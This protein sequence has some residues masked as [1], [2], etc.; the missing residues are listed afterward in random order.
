MLVFIYLDFIERNTTNNFWWCSGCFFLVWWTHAQWQ[1]LTVSSRFSFCC[2]F[3]FGV[4]LMNC[5]VSNKDCNHSKGLLL[6]FFFKNYYFLHL[7]FKCYPK[8]SLYF[9]FHSIDN[10]EHPLLCLPGIALQKTAISGSFQQNLAG[11]FLNRSTCP[12]SY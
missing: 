2:S 10:C 7:H 5:T 6:F 1:S 4:L 11:I 9:V 3:M 12:L 8:S